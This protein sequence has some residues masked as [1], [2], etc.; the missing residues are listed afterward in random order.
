MFS[1]VIRLKIRVI[2]MEL[3]KQIQDDMKAAM[4]A[5]DSLK[6]GALRMLLASLT[7]KEKEKNEGELSEEEVQQVIAAEAKKRREAAEAFE[8]GGKA[9]M[10]QQEKAELAIFQAYLPEQLGEDEIRRLVQEAIAETQ[11]SSPQDMGKVMAALM[12]KT[13]GRA[14]GAFVSKIVK[15][16]LTG[17]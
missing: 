4:K 11:A 15:E 6:T 2:S 12:P 1:A 16:S 10:A 7:N 13:K 8:Q 3:K 5:G 9:E 14:D 17:Q